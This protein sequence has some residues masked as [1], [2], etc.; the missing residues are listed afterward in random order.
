MLKRMKKIILSTLLILVSA[1]IALAAGKDICDKMPDPTFREF[2]RS[3][4][5]ID[6]DGV[7]T[8]KEAAVVEQIDVKGKNIS[9]L[10]GIEFFTNLTKLDCSNNKL[11]TLSLAK[12]KN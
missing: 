2:C 8:K 7:L 12:T 3:N 10:A 1:N 5:D 4:F 9:S 6:K 11:T